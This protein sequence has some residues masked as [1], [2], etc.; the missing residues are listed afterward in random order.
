MKVLV[1]GGTG[2][3]GRS[4][5]DHLLEM[6]HTVRLLSRSAADDALEWAAGVEPFAGSVSDA[7]AVQGAAEGCGAVLHV[8]GIA[9]EIP[10]EATFRRVNVEG[11][12]NV[13]REARRAG[14]GRFVYVSSLGAGVGR[15][16]YHRSKLEGEEVVR[17]EN[18]R[19]WLVV[20]PGNVYGPGDQVM[21]LLL[22]A[23]RT[24]PAIPVIGFG[25]QPFQ[26]VWV[27][28]VGLALARAVDHDQPAGVVVE[29]A[30][31]EV[32]TTDEILD[33]LAA[34][35]GKKPR[36]LPVPGAVAKLGSQVAEAMGIDVPVTDDQIT[37][38]LE[39]NVITAGKPNGLTEVFGVTP[40][41][42]AEGLTKL[43]DHL[44]EQLPSEGVGRMLR[45]RYWADVRD[46]R[47]SAEELLE[48]IR[49]E[50]HTFPPPDLISVGAEPGTP[51]A[52]D[53]GATVTMAIPF[54]GHVQ[55]RV[56]QVSPRSITLATVEGH[57]LAGV[58]RFM[59]REP[60]PGRLRFE[61]RSYARASR[62]L[63]SLGMAAVGQRLQKAT[64]KGMVEGVVNRC[65]GEKWGEVQEETR[66]LTDAEAAHL[67]DA[68]EKLVR[69]RR[70]RLAAE[71][72][73]DSVG[74]AGA[75]HA[76]GGGPAG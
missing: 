34:I 25:G 30:G 12:R 74:R 35:T 44:P 14:V 1:T 36:R 57:L 26:P 55:V 31:P 72:A 67:E 22:K 76:E 24:L 13:A 27:D 45:Q 20:R 17:R 53:E 23:V 32:T 61:V 65:G 71:E 9:V 48:A 59:V 58:I 41:P 52:L 2:L 38:L 51:L 29:V 46:S 43:A 3:V 21:S 40:T 39:G 37:M 15:S 50:F 16:D 6:G 8:A 69:R 54:R 4:A 75:R 42:L 66:R 7:A 18:P 10:P 63:D 28:D 47:L 70:Q 73:E 5:V 64:W 60:A 19:C 56:E 68:V 62:L 33:K 11:T 49:A